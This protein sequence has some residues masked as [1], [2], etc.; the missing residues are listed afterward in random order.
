[1]KAG[2]A[3]VRIIDRKPVNLDEEDWRGTIVGGARNIASFATDENPLAGYVIVGLFK[4]GSSSVGWKYD[5]DMA[6]VPRA[7]LPHWIAELIRRD[8]L[9][10]GEAKSVFEQMFEWVE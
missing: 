10:Y 5:P 1:M 9:T 8:I 4:D 6:G 7:L 3:D 2:G